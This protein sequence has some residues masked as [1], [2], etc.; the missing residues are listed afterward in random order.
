M[1][2]WRLQINR[3]VSNHHSKGAVEQHPSKN[4]KDA[5]K[6]KDLRALQLW[7]EA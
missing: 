2:K 3:N 1:N 7:N 4:E 6:K 5:K